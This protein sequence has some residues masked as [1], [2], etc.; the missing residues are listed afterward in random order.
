MKI[1]AP[2]SRGHEDRAGEV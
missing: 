1:I 2:Y